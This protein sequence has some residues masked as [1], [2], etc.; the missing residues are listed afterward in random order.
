MCILCS[1]GCTKTFFLKVNASPLKERTLPFLEFLAVHL[2]LKCLIAIFN[3]G[4]TPLQLPVQCMHH[5]YS[6]SLAGWYSICTAEA[7]LD[8]CFAELVF[9]GLPYLPFGCIIF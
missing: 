7:I 4:L 2:A 3:D 8:N 9:C 6:G 1:V 5:R